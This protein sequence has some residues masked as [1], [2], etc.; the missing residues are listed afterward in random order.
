MFLFKHTLITIL[1]HSCISFFVILSLRYPKVVAYFPTWCCS[2]FVLSIPK[3]LNSMIY[4]TIVPFI[5]SFHPYSQ[6]FDFSLVFLYLAF[7]MWL[8]INL[9][10]SASSIQMIICTRFCSMLHTL[11]NIG[12]KG[13]ALQ[14]PEFTVI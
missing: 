8:Q 6:T 2:P 7:L 11:N 10:F 9:V 5:F 3:Y 13:F 14:I 1:Q 12:L 4:S